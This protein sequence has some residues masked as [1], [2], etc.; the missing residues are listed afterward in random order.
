MSSNK[1]RDMEASDDD[2][3]Y[4]EDY[5]DEGR[6]HDAL[7]R[8]I[9]MLCQKC[10]EYERIVKRLKMELR[11]LKS[12]ARQTKGQIRID[13]DW[14]G[15]EANFANLVSSFVKE[16]LFPHHKFLKNGWMEYDNGPESLLTFVQGKVK[17]PVGAEYK[18]QWERFICP[19]IQVKYVTRRYNINNEI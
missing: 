6:L 10:V 16:Y 8:K 15:K 12:H 4:N 1:N 3:E 5:K 18:N 14:D 19:T 11:L 2:N 17:I 7:L 9:G 13:Y